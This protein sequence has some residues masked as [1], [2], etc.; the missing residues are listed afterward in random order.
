M[1]VTLILLHS[2]LHSFLK[3]LKLIFFMTLFL[4]NPFPSLYGYTG[5]DLASCLFISLVISINHSCHF[6]SYHCLFLFYLYPTVS[7]NKWSSAWCSTFTVTL[8]QPL[9]TVLTSYSYHFQVIS[10]LVIHLMFLGYLLLLLL[11]LL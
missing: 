6:I 3:N 5:I 11:L 8:N 1:R 10:V 4:L 2:L 7:E 9:F